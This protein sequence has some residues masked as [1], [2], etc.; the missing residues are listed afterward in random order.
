LEAI[1]EETLNERL[2]RRLK[3]RVE[4]GDFRVCAAHDLAPVFEKSFGVK[5]KELARN[6]RF[7]EVMGRCGLKLRECEDEQREEGGKVKGIKKEGKGKVS[8]ER[9]V[10]VEKVTLWWK[11]RLREEGSEKVRV[12]PSYQQQRWLHDNASVSPSDEELLCWVYSS[13]ANVSD[14]FFQATIRRPTTS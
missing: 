6:E 14:S 12:L 1:I 13:L 7:K 8:D 5:E 2:E 11:F 4:S 9:R 10:E 3:K